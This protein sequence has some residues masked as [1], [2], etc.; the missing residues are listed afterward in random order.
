M[1]GFAS[2][3]QL[4]FVND[5]YKLLPFLSAVNKYWKDF[6]ALGDIFMGLIFERQNIWTVV[7]NIK[8]VLSLLGIPNE[9]LIDNEVPQDLS[10]LLKS[11]PQINLD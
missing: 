8:K 1:G 6:C 11:Y 7:S 10:E 3:T 4:I 2:Q 5:K 9:R